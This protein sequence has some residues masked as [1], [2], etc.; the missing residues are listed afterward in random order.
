[1][2]H[3]T[4]I[5]NSVVQNLE[6]GPVQAHISE[7]IQGKPVTLVTSGL[8]QVAPALMWV[9]HVASLV[10]SH[11]DLRVG[12]GVHFVGQTSVGPCW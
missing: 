6:R 2:G 10:L 11:S 12:P 8:Q 4:R 7:V 5:A 3:L 9:D 1:M